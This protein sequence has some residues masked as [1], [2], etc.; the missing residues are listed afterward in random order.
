M[1]ARS[2][3]QA[4]RLRRAETVDVPQAAQL[5]ENSR[6]LAALKKL[7]EVEKYA[8]SSLALIRLKEE[9]VTLPS[10]INTT[11]QG[12]E[13]YATD[14]ADP[15]AADFAHWEHLG[16]SPVKTDQ[17]PRDGFSRIRIIKDGYEPVEV[18]SSV[19]RRLNVQLHTKE[20]TPPGMVWIPVEES[21]PLTVLG[22]QLP[23]VQKIPAIWM[24]RYEVTNRQFK[25]FVDKG[26][27]QRPE[28]WKERFVKDG[29]VLQFEEAMQDFRDATGKPGPSTW[30]GSYPDGAA[31][32]P[33]GG[34]SWYEASA[35]AE[36]AH[37][38][39]PTVYHWYIA[40]GIGITSQ[41]IPWSNFGLKGPVAGGT[42]LGLGPYGNYDMAGN[43]KEWTVNSSGDK[44]FILGGG[45]NEPS[46]MFQNGDA[47]SPWDREET[48]G[49]RCALS[50]SPIPEAL[51]G[52]VVKVER[53]RTGE[54]PVD[55]HTFDIYMKSLTYDKTDLKVQQGPVTDAPRWREEDVSFQAAYGKER[56]ILHLF[57]PR[58]ASPPYQAVFFS[59]GNN[60]RFAKTP[61][62]VWTRLTDWIVKSGRAVVLPAYAGTLDRGPTY[63]PVPP[64]KDRE[65]QIESILDVSRSIDYLETRKDI[66]TSRLAF[67]GVSFGSGLGL[68]VVTAEPR[69]KAAV[70]LS[71]GY[72]P[73]TA[74]PDVDSWNYAPRVKVP[75]LMLSGEDDSMAPMKSSQIP[76]FNALGT[77]KKEYHHYPGGHVDYINRE[78]VI[79]EALKWLNNN[80]GDVN[81]RP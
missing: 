46:Y 25:E 24:D 42:T 45:W 33:V 34:V 12:A 63:P 54:P 64:G 38:K 39:L 41:I 79:K 28:L 48:F 35:Y 11:P 53:N 27:Y 75:V 47:R 14:Y 52:T 13:I 23:L 81:L 19:L 44:R 31:D 3:V 16:R 32:L 68:R 36:F 1:G 66:D 49:F 71:L 72:S 2:Y 10:T 61:E 7:R 62:E 76:M 18:T 26:G 59:A 20:D 17:L 37:K 80:L 57:L 74:L 8:P 6:P 5:L 67:A 50:V 9:I 77:S 69:F 43:V 56:V 60:M 4:S 70:L 15:S 58:D 78:E 21:T 40:A 51:N 65:L 73:A 30:D 29:K 22:V 55:D